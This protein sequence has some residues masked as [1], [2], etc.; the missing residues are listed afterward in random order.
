VEDRSAPELHGEEA[1]MTE[2]TPKQAREDDLIKALTTGL[3][4]LTTQEGVDWHALCHQ[5]I[6][7]VVMPQVEPLLN[8]LDEVATA[9]ER[10]TKSHECFVEEYAH[11]GAEAKGAQW[12][13]ERLLKKLRYFEPHD[14]TYISRFSATPH[15]IHRILKDGL[16]EDTYLNYQRF[17]VEPAVSEVAKEVRDLADRFNPGSVTG[18]AQKGAA[19]Y[20]D[21]KQGGGRWP[22]SLI[23]PS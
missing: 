16:C 18:A 8:A 23:N 14:W 22:A 2:K 4:E 12:E 10:I 20:F 7:Q 13:M 17:I 19:D 21:P 9:A 1:P 6:H 11:P 15:E 5:V 3:H